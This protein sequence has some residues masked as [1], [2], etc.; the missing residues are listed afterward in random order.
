VRQGGTAGAGGAVHR[1][2][3]VLGVGSELRTRIL[4]RRRRWQ[5]GE[6]GRRKRKRK[7]KRDGRR[8]ASGQPGSLACRRK[9]PS[10][11]VTHHGR[12]RFPLVDPPQAPACDRS[13]L[14]FAL[15]CA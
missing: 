5:A 14:P 9:N 6:D 13:S 8:S 3:E 2:G 15:V 10:L 1:G 11:N 12:R 7:R 4:R